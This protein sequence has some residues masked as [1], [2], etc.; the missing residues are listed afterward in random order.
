[1]ARK[2]AWYFAAF[3]L[4]IGSLLFVGN[5]SNE[6]YSRKA[7]QP[8]NPPISYDMANRKAKAAAPMDGT[9]S[10]AAEEKWLPLAGNVWPGV[11]VYMGAKDDK[12]A[13]FT[14][15]D[16]DENHQ[17]IEPDGT[18]SNYRGI[19]VQYPDGTIEWK[20]RYTLIRNAYLFVRKDDPNL[21]K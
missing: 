17:R 12:K 11:E 1:M 19:E 9:E 13:Q 20:D 2:A 14:V 7:K 16:F 15:L 3:C 10:A 21:V 6:Y 4:W 8:T 5:Y 18:I